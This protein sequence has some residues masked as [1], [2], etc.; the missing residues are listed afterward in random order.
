MA[1]PETLRR[2]QNHWS[3]CL[4]CLLPGWAGEKRGQLQTQ[5]VEMLFF[6]F[7]SMAH[8]EVTGDLF[9]MPLCRQG[10]GFETYTL[11]SKD[12]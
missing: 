6:F 5:P 2:N 7:G 12:H 4:A 10:S 11:G 1:K 3:F 8:T 9:A